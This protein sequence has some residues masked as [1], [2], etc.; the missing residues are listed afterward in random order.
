MATARTPRQHSEKSLEIK[1]YPDEGFYK[2]KHE[3]A[4]KQQS[5]N[6][7]KTQKTTY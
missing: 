7:R 1:E 6:F 2:L 4:G 5:K 3:I